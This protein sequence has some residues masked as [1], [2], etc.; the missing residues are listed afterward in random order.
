[1]TANE[2]LKKREIGEERQKK[3]SDRYDTFIEAYKEFISSPLIPVSDE[4]KAAVCLNRSLLLGVVHSYFDDIE[5][6]KEYTGAVCADQHKQAAYTIK[7]IVKFKPIQ[8]KIDDDSV[9]IYKTMSDGLIQINSFFAI[10][11]GFTLFLDKRLFSLM[12]KDFFTHIVYD[13]LFRQVSGKQLSTV[14]FLMEKIVD[15]HY[16]PSEDFKI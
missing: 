14:L 1:M 4:I 3:E 15:C 2:K 11:V 9:D 7:W 5:R 12:S 6:F 10:Y 13:T 8:I 16:N